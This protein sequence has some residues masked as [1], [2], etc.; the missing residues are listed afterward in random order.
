MAIF[1]AEDFELELKFIGSKTDS[2]FVVTISVTCIVYSGKT[3]FYVCKE[4]CYGFVQ[5]LTELYNSLKVGKAILS[6]YEPDQNNL[7]FDS[8]G[9]GNFTISGVFNNWGDWTLKFE[10]SFDQTYFKH[11]IKQLNDE[12]SEL[13]K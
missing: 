4:Q 9:T 3:T 7:C 12:L 6:D 2:V 1:K 8:D 11:F 13:Y 5:D 10:K